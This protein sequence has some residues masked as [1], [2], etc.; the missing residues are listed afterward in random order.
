MSDELNTTLTVHGYHPQHGALVSAAEVEKL[1]EPIIT[2]TSSLKDSFLEQLEF[3]KSMGEK[4]KAMQQELGRLEGENKRSNELLSECWNMVGNDID[5]EHGGFSTIC[6]HVNAQREA[7]AAAEQRVKELEK[8]CL[9]PKVTDLIRCGIGG[10]YGGDCYDKAI[11][12]IYE[13]VI[14]LR[15]KVGE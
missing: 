11:A 10:N 13:P 1:M 2:E 12:E 3:T 14:Q 4:V 7:L 15:A 5:F 9:N 6:E 8:A